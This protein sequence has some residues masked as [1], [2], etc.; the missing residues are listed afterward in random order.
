M[1]SSSREELTPEEKLVDE[2]VGIGMQIKGKVSDDAPLDKQREIKS[3]VK[4]VWA[5][6]ATCEEIEKTYFENVQKSIYSEE[7]RVKKVK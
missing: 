5:N 1:E 3:V 6:G 4:K 7:K 2:L